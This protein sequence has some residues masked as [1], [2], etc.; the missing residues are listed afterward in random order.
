MNC[1]RQTFKKSFIICSGL[2]AL[3]TGPG[4]HTPPVTETPERL[5][6]AATPV[7]VPMEVPGQGQGETAPSALA[8]GTQAVTEEAVGERG[9][10][11]MED[12]GIIREPR[13]SGVEPREEEEVRTDRVGELHLAGTKS[14][15]TASRTL[16]R[17]HRQERSFRH[18]GL[19][20][21]T[22]TTATTGLAAT[23][24]VTPVDNVQV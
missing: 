7:Q 21:E 11:I 19:C 5:R 2:S 1:Q 9:E 17:R 20:Q 3:R 14:T 6:M 23:T 22:T 18:Q 24:A 16:L 12:R 10:E 13:G 8:P 15:T 4:S